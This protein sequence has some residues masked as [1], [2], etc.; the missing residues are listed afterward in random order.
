MDQRNGECQ[1]TKHVTTLP[2][3]IYVVSILQWIN[4]KNENLKMELENFVSRQVAR[5]KGKMYLEK[6]GK[7]YLDEEGKMYVDEKG[8]WKG[9]YKI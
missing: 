9:P 3:Y 7:T 2:D 6:K 5:E 4:D 1:L 8:K